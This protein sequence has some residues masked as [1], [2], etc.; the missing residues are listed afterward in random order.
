MKNKSGVLEQVMTNAVKNQTVFHPRKNGGE[1]RYEKRRG[2]KTHHPKDLS[3]VLT[4]ST[5]EQK[6]HHPNPRA[7]FPPQNKK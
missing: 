5:G 1:K 2:K 6:I 7:V 3:R 4:G